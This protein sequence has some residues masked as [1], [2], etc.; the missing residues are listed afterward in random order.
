[1]C[2]YYKLVADPRLNMAFRIMKDG[3]I[4]GV[5]LF[6]V[7]I[8][9]FYDNFIQIHTLYSG[10]SLKTFFIHNNPGFTGNWIEYLVR[11]F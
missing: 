7:P 4:N 8:I 1:M 11:V 3:M 6:F 2:I 5:P 9:F 10:Y